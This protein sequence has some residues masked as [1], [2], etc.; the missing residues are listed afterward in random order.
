[1]IDHYPVEFTLSDGTKV[2]VNKTDEQ[3]YEFHLTRLNSSKY[4]FTWNENT[5]KV[6]SDYATGLDNNAVTQDEKEALV[7]FWQMKK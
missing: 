6:I 2:L 5:G 4:N 7:T 3:S 1:M